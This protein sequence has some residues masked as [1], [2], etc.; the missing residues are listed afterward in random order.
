M[1]Q[2]E[3]IEGTQGS[4]EVKKNLPSK[5]INS[6]KAQWRIFRRLRL[7]LETNPTVKIFLL[8]SSKVRVVVRIRP[9]LKSE[10][11]AGDTKDGQIVSIVR[12]EAS[13][14]S[15]SV[16]LNEQFQNVLGEPV[17]NESILG[18]V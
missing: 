11:D 3:G 18:P 8:M 14:G 7:H 17:V 13:K 10:I 12:N 15:C 6:E 9:F 1:E 2:P 4:L 16:R 5:N